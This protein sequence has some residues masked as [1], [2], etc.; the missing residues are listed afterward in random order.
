MPLFLL[1]SRPGVG[2]GVGA[3]EGTI[4]YLYLYSVTQTLVTMFPEKIK[5]KK[6]C[7]TV[8]NF[9]YTVFTQTI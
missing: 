5:N 2:V 4:R 8:S 9:Y 6:F 1:V 3:A 7:I